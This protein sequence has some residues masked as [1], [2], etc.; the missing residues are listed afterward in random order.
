[1]YCQ[2]LLY[3]STS[4]PRHQYTPRANNTPS[5]V[6]LLDMYI[7]TK[8]MAF[9][10]NNLVFMARNRHALRRERIFRDRRNHIDALTEAELI[11]RYRFDRAGIMELVHI[12]EAD[13]QDPTARN[14]AL[15]PLQQVMV[16]ILC[17]GIHVDRCGQRKLLS[18][19]LK[20]REQFMLCLWHWPAG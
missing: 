3:Y 2:C 19:N 13:M 7:P 15:T 17:N 20:C 8:K 10:L 18:H 14:H 6:Q 9:Y 11:S 1:M 16:S 12:T 5:T 4:S